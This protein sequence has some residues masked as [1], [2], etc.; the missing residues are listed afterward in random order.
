MMKNRGFT[1]VELLV[2]IVIMGIITAI[3]I[4]MIRNIREGNKDIAVVSSKT[5][6]IV[7]SG[8]LTGTAK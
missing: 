6:N 3:A 7:E 1:L 2:A 4:P 8:T 5:V